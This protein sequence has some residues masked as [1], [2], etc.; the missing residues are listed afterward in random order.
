LAAAEVRDI[1]AVVVL[2]VFCADFLAVRPSVVVASLAAAAAS[3]VAIFEVVSVAFTPL[4]LGLAVE[5]APF[6]MLFACSRDG[7]PRCCD[8]GA[9][10][11]GRPDH[12]ADMSERS[13]P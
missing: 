5:S 4:E 7:A 9:C 3:P 13:T 11:L 6:F 8:G 1:P 2:N 12:R 10:G